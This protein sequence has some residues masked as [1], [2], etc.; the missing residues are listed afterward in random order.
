M[1]I[2]RGDE[3]SQVSVTS[4]GRADPQIERDLEQAVNGLA[5]GEM[6]RMYRGICLVIG[7][8]GPA[9]HILWIDDK[10]NYTS[11]NYAEKTG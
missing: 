5:V 7:N 2:T 9:R 11:F 10:T 8:Y 4:D 6:T 3:Q 1:E